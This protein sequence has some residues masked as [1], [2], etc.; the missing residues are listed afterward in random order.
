V[1]SYI[2]SVVIGKIEPVSKVIDSWI[3]KSEARE[4]TPMVSAAN[5]VGQNV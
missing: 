3:Q 4:Q 1:L 2:I 5:L